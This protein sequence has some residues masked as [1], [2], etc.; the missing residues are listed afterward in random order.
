MGEKMIKIAVVE[1]EDKE[2]EKLTAALKRYE[3]E[4]C[5]GGVLF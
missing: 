5:G 3:T 4:D 2:A 1:D